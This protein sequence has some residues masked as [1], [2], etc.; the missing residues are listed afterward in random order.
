[1]PVTKQII[2]I[3]TRFKD[4][5]RAPMQ[6]L[7]SVMAEHNKK[8][9]QN[10]KALGGFNFSWLSVMFAGMALYRV[11]G[12]ILRQQMELW[13]IME[14]FSAM[15]MIVMLP[16]METLSDALWPILEWFMNLPEPAQRVIGLLIVFAAVVGAVLLVS[17]MLMLALYGLLPILAALTPAL[18]GMGIAVGSVILIILGIIAV[19][20][21]VYLAWKT[22]FLGMKE[23]VDKFV[24]G[25]KQVFGGVIMI[26]KGIMK[27]LQGILTGDF[28]LLKKGIMMVFKGL[29]QYLIGGFK[30]TAA[31]VLGI[32]KTALMVIYN[33]VKVLI[34]G[35]IWIINKLSSLGGK[36]GG[37]IN[38][39]MPSL[40]MGGMVPA[41]GPYLL[42]R[43]ERVT[44]SN[45]AGE[46]VNLN[47]TYN[48][49]VSDKAELEKIMREN[50]IRLAEDVRRIV[51]T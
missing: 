42:H 50:N 46:E 31:V 28:E 40:Q 16:V 48:I 15:L 20:A 23:T 27:G 13:G 30:A 37:A 18:A 32:M 25:I 26:F 7:N 11:F 35:I 43:G 39:R 33:F 44:P 38:W 17:G 51:Q 24:K 41:T 34:D 14:G 12:G 22:N 3:I 8:V 45:K 49:N 10:S 19:L 29:W 1:M 47:V 5:A 36:R 21:L 9:Q 6:K 4:A 2:E